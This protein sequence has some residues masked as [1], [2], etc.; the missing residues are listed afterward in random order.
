MRRIIKIRLI[1]SFIQIIISLD[2]LPLS[3]PLIRFFF[4]P[5][6][7]LFKRKPESDINVKTNFSLFNIKL[8]SEC[9]LKFLCSCRRHQTLE[10]W[11]KGIKFKMRVA[12][13]ILFLLNFSQ[14]PLPRKSV[15][16]SKCISVYK[17]MGYKNV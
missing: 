13:F 3:F 8:R 11:Q 5:S 2:L 6:I 7:Y 16:L 15:I 9:E 12:N 17:N 14:Q 1:S 4:T 10:W